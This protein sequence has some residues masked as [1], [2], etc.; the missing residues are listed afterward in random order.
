VNQLKINLGQAFK[1]MQEIG[2]VNDRYVF[3]EHTMFNNWTP[4]RTWLKEHGVHTTQIDKDHGTVLFNFA[5]QVQMSMF[6]I[7]FPDWVV[8]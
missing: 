2:I 1:H 3:K 7:D 5:D 8:S 4:A 6:Q